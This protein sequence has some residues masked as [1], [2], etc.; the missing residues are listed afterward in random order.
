MSKATQRAGLSP[1]LS[2]GEVAL[3]TG[4][5]VSALHFYEASGLIRSRRSGGNQRR[6]PREVLRRVGVI[7]AAQRLGV[8][9]ETIR[10]ALAT[11]PEGRTPTA[12]D[13]ARLSAAWRAELDDRIARLIRLRD[14]LDG[15][16]GCGCLS[17]K[18]CPLRNPG[19]RLGQEGPG[20][21]YLEPR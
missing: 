1:E 15:C 5:A 19:D 3:R 20:A 7:K 13:W 12:K 8:R 16:I 17:L 11:L 4:V 2:V 14:S 6:Y 21:R 10:D 18:T 9:L